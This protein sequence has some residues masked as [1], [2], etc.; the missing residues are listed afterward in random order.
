LSLTING[1]SSSKH[2]K[3][4]KYRQQRG[5]IRCTLDRNTFNIEL[6]AN[7]TSLDK[8]SELNVGLLCLEDA[9]GSNWLSWD[10]AVQVG[11][12]STY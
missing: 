1:K 6:Q 8:I 5:Q 3:F 7:A 12:L 9:T 10:G 4:A 2:R 11:T